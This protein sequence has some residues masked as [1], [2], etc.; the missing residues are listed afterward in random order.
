[1]DTWEALY[2][3]WSSFGIPA[4]DESS[5][6]SDAVLPYISYRPAAGILGETVSMGA[7]I[8]SRSR[9]WE[10]AD[11]IADRIAEKIGRGGINISVDNGAVWIKRGTEFAQHMSDPDDT[12]RRIYLM[13]EVEFFI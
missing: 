2:N 8:W 4:Y 5:V 3:F 10:E 7:S 9:S 13:I 1:M 6:P 12:I 11:G